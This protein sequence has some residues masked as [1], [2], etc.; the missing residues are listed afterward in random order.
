MIFAAA[1]SARDVF[2]YLRIAGL[3]LLGVVVVVVVVDGGGGVVVILVLVL[4]QNLFLF[5]KLYLSKKSL[6]FVPLLM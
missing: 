3:R 6:K 4:F 1:A 5:S 2:F